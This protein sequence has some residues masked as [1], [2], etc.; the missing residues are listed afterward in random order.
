MTEVLEELRGGEA[1]AAWRAGGRLDTDELTDALTAALTDRATGYGAL[2]EEEIGDGDDATVVAL[3]LVDLRRDCAPDERTDPYMIRVQT[4]GYDSVRPGELRE[5][6]ETMQ[7]GGDL[8]LHEVNSY[9]IHRAAASFLVV[10]CSTVP[11]AEIEAVAWQLNVL[12]AG[13]RLRRPE[14]FWSAEGEDDDGDE[15]DGEED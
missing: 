10:G 15:W 13:E 3:R 4:S 12:P 11:L 9:G 1:A 8:E 2:Y 14:P 5:L 6:V 7:R